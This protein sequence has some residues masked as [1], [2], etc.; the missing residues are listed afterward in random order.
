MMRAEYLMTARYK[1]ALGAA[2]ISMACAWPL[3][4]ARADVALRD[5]SGN[6]VTKIDSSRMVSV[7]GS[8]TEILY[9]IGRQDRIVAIDSTSAFPEA[10]KQKPNVGYM[11]ALSPEGVL[12]LNPSLVLAIEGSGPPQTISVLQ[13]ASV[14]FVMVPD[15]FTGEGLVEK[16]HTV[17]LAAGDTARGDCVAK[18]VQGDLDGLAALRKSIAKPVRVAFV[19]SF[20]NGRPMVA[21]KNTAAE[22]I[23]ALSGAV[24]AIEGFDGYKQVNDEAVIAAKPDVVLVMNRDSHPMSADEVF[25]HPAF[26]L[27]PAGERKAF[28]GMGALYLLGFGPRTARAARDLAIQL[29]PTL[30]SGTLPSDKT[31]AIA[32]CVK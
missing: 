28:V 29:Y 7:G 21:G 26:K 2:L 23:I 10:A 16:I 25:A 8:I 22:G 14:P 17:A 24:N 1:R 11:R 27:T 3:T 4:A 9:A 20:V 19:L 6:A 18:A 31:D 12:G 15:R 13:A 30:A 32:A 5:A